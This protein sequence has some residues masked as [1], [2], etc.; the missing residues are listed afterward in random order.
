M[1]GVA[2]GGRSADYVHGTISQ[3]NPAG[4]KSS[5]GLAGAWWL[6]QVSRS[7]VCPLVKVRRDALYRVVGRTQDDNA[8]KAQNA[9]PGGRHRAQVLMLWSPPHTYLVVPQTPPSTGAQK[10]QA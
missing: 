4:F 6:Q 1:W 2:G 3:V 5:L 9:G 7:P 8:C 10:R